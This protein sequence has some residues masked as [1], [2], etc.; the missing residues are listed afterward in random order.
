M[1]G[2]SDS[3]TP[4][5]AFRSSFY[6]LFSLSSQTF[7][8]LSESQFKLS[9]L[10][11]SSVK[12]ENRNKYETGKLNV[13]RFC[14]LVS[15]SAISHSKRKQAAAELHLSSQLLSFEKSKQFETKLKI[16]MACF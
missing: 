3:L 10:D 16:K 12:V 2:I 14:R 7:V 6:F 9:F 13:E 4:F 11:F 5:P 1:Y 8:Q 15:V